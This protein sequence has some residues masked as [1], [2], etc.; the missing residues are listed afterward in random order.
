MANSVLS[1]KGSLLL[2]HVNL[3]IPQIKAC[4]KGENHLWISLFDPMWVPWQRCVFSL[5][6]S[7]DQNTYNIPR[8]S[9]GAFRR[10]P[11]HP[12]KK[13]CVA[14]FAFSLVYDRNHCC[15]HGGLGTSPNRPE[16]G[17]HRMEQL[18]TAYILCSGPCWA[19]QR[20]T[21]GAAG[22]GCPPSPS[23]HRPHLGPIW[24]HDMSPVLRA[25]PHIGSVLH[26]LRGAAQVFQALAQG[27][28]M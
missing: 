12:K 4:Q 6:G 19:V 7:G 23:P 17:A 24:G 15:G 14:C 11:L 22:G 18:Q 8:E 28:G 9:I 13:S 10:V 1:P 20:G 26:L 2:T 5:W 16:R 27:L 25:S 3:G 21:G